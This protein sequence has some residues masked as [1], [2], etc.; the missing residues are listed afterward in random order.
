MSPAKIKEES[1]ISSTLVCFFNFLVFTSLMAGLG[2]SCEGESLLVDL[3]RLTCAPHFEQKAAPCGNS[4]P[5][6]VQYT[7]NPFFV[8]SPSA[9]APTLYHNYF[10][11]SIFVIKT[12]SSPRLP[13]L[14][15]R[16]GSPQG[17]GVL[18][19]PKHHLFPH[20]FFLVFKK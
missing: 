17:T 11:L 12:V 2:E 8:L 6:F 16:R 18:D 19:G 14:G 3:S 15:A 10:Q 20:H 7:M 9:N 5:H 13:P 4:V 1:T